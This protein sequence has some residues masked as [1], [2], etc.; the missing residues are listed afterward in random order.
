MTKV[1]RMKQ[2][3]ILNST[4]EFTVKGIHAKLEKYGVSKHHLAT[5]ISKQVKAGNF[6]RVRVEGAGI[7]RQ[8]TYSR[9]PADK[10][11]QLKQEKLPLDPPAIPDNL[12]LTVV[13]EAIYATFKLLKF[14]VFKAEEQIEKLGAECNRLRKECRD[15]R[16]NVEAKNQELETI[17][18]ALKTKTGKTFP[19][20]EVAR[21]IRN[22]RLIEPR[23]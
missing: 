22:G 7:N 21:V 14:Q 5:F 11:K 9:K 3:I 19:M 18:E 13:G 4:D 15:M 2:A 23:T 10:T 20:S 8:V 6:R 16:K 17:R 12:P 1:E